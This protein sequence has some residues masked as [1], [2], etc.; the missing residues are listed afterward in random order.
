MPDAG[1][2]GSAIATVCTRSIGRGLSGLS[3]LMETAKENGTVRIM[4]TWKMDEYRNE[5]YLAH[6]QIQEQRDRIMKIQQ[7]GIK[8]IKEEGLNVE[9]VWSGQR[10]PK[11]IMTVDERALLYLFYYDFIERIREHSLIRGRGIA[12]AGYDKSHYP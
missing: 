1:L 2:I 4:V 10:K 8:K 9:I 6:H 7:E 5:R 3:R 12:S 11:T